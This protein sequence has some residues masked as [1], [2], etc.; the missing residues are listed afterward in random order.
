MRRLDPATLLLTCLTAAC[1]H[2]PDPGAVVPAPVVEASRRL[3]EL[4]EQRVHSGDFSGVV[5]LAHR[6]RPVLLKAAGQADRETGRPIGPETPFVVASTTQTFTAAGVR[7]LIAEGRLR[8]ETRVVEILP[9]LAGS[10]LRDL[11]VAQL[12]THTEGLGSVVRNPRFRQSPS[13][14][15]SLADY[16]E[17]VV[18]EP[19]GEPGRFEYGDADS[20]ILAAM[21]ERVAGKPFDAF[22]R[23]RIFELLGMEHSGFR[24]SPRPEGLARGYTRRDLGGPSYGAGDALVPNDR[25]LPALASP[26]AGAWTTAGD[27]LLFAEAIRTGKLSGSG[28][29]LLK[30]RVAAGREPPND[31]YGDGFFDGRVGTLRVVSHGGTGPG[32]DVCFDLYP[33]LDTVLVILSNLD[34][35]ACQV[36]RVAV[37]TSLGAAARST[38][39]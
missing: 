35:P 19:V 8:E 9:E 15:A 10:A 29:P 26:G 17:V 36:L 4:T 31:H 7:L 39:G 13:S 23:T 5:L 32:I 6:G 12:L 27:L 25:I 22:L 37:R 30:G 21:A 34:P 24:L 1:A 2:G 11:T 28:E 20:V 38:P 18:K 3:E 33:E 14:F 16:L